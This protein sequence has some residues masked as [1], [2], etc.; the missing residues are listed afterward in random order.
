MEKRKAERVKFFQLGM[1]T[2]IQPIWVFRQTCP[3]STLGLLLDISA[4]GAQVLPH[5]SNER[6]GETYCLVIQQLD[7]PGNEVLRATVW[8]C[9]SHDDGTLYT[10]SG[11]IFDEQASVQRVLAVHDAGSRWLRCEL[12][13]V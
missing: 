13:R 6:P 9:W 7:K 4:D 5:R 10:R 1:G 2:E 12:L 8:C 3:E 11:F